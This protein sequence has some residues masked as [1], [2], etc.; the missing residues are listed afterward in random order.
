MSHLGATFFRCHSCE[1]RVARFG[2]FTI[3]LELVEGLQRHA[4][5]TLLAAVAT[6]L[7]LIAMLWFG[8]LSLSS[9]QAV[10]FL[11]PRG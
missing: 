9:T 5:L 4:R 10:V 8:R 3:R 1:L 7:I 11:W 6:L 2:V